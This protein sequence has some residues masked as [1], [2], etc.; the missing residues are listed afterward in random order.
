MQRQNAVYDRIFEGLAVGD[1]LAFCNCGAYSVTEGIYL[2]LSRDMP[3]IYLVEGGKTRLVRDTV[4]TDVWNGYPTE[5]VS[6][7]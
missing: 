1:E 2:F 7:Q 3:R 6:I 4:R 5:P